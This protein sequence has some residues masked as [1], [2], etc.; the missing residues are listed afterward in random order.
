VAECRNGTKAVAQP[1]LDGFCLLDGS[2]RKQQRG[3]P[4]SANLAFLT[5]GSPPVLL[6]LAMCG[7]ASR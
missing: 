3:R 6:L 5:S 1:A 7:E 2:T 4:R